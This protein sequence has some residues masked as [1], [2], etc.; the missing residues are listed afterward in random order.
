MAAAVRLL[1][2][3]GLPRRRIVIAGTSQGAGVAILALAQL[4]AEGG[5]LGGAL[6]ESPFLDL[7][8]AARN[9][10]R[11]LLGSAEP[12][13]RLAER[14]ALARAGRVAGFDP[15]RVSPRLAVR[16]LRTPLAFLAGQG[17][18]VTPLPGVRT[19]AETGG[20]P[21]SIVVCDGHCE[22]GAR[23]PGGWGGWAKGHLD[24]WDP[25]SQQGLRKIPKENP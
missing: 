20:S 6:L 5:P 4:E 22:A 24:R 25:A 18:P 19:L 16:G 1:E 2:S 12:L 21:L 10:V 9:H 14:I 7:R 13:G 8:D 15:D 3:E 23:V 17:D 11:G